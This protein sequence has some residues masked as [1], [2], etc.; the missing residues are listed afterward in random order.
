MSGLVVIKPLQKVRSFSGLVN[1]TGKIIELSI[2]ASTVTIRVD[3]NV[4]VYVDLLGNLP[5]IPSDPSVET[6]FVATPKIIK[7][8]DG[9]WSADIEFQRIALRTKPG[10]TAVVRVDVG[11]QHVQSRR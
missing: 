11:Y 4:E 6:D 9:S 5:E 10:E 7:P 8:S 1:N 2:P 3:S